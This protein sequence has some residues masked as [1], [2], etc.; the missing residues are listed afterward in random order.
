M[1]L[2]RSHGEIPAIKIR[3]KSLRTSEF[4]K[5]GVRPKYTSLLEWWAARDLFYLFFI[6]TYSG[7]R[8]NLFIR[9]QGSY[10]IFTVICCKHHA[11]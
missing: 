11:V 1:K 8:F 7:T 4:E 2:R 3:R 10:N 9:H 6:S 5:T